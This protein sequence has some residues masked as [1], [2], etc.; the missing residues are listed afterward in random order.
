MYCQNIHA[1]QQVRSVNHKLKGIVYNIRQKELSEVA[2][3]YQ[4]RLI[5]NNLM[6]E[7]VRW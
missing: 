7:R 5:F 3:W 1:Y 2:D 6:V 4:L